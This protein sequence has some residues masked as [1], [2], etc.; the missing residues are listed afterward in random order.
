MKL[1]DRYIIKQFVLN[2]VILSVVMMGLYVLVDLI[3]DL[4]EFLDAG[5]ELADQHG[6]ALLATLWV[7]GDYYGPFL[8]LV[9]V[10]MSGLIVVAAMGFTVAQMQRNRELIALLAGGISLYRVAAPILVTGFVFNLVAL[11]VQEVLIPPLAEKIVRPKSQAGSLTIKDKPVHYLKDESG[12]LI[13]ASSFSAERGEMQDV[14]IIKLNADG[15]QESLIRA[16]L[17]TWDAA[18]G[19]WILKDGRRFVPGVDPADPDAL[20]GTAV[21]AYA[22]ELSS[23]V[24][25]VRQASLFLRLLSMRELEAMRG[26]QALTAKARAS[27]TQIIWSR[28]STVVLSVLILLMGLP[29]FLSRVPGNLL[30]NATKAAGI[31]VGA[32]SGGLV[33][34]QVGNLNPVTAAWLPVIIYLPISFW[35]VTKIET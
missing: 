22:T 24:L 15:R 16:S 6:G 28:F 12:A 25:I 33:L 19:Q 14:R 18:S 21:N 27:V 1:L 4:D 23:D 10:A 5:Q 13:S 35:L 8:L 31:T 9:Y 2:F 29:Y 34:L 32:W 20:A 11:P 3:V 26:N 30:V 7:L 17:A